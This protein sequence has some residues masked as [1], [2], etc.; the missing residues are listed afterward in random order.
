MKVA[1]LLLVS[2]AANDVVAT[3]SGSDDPVVSE[4]RCYH[5]KAG[6]LGLT[7]SVDVKIDD[8]ASNSAGHIEVVGE[9]I[10]G[11]TCSDK[12]F[13]K[14]GQDITTDLSDCQPSGISIPS[15][16]YCSD[17]DS[18]QVTVRADAVPIPVKATLSRVDCASEQ[19]VASCSGSSDPDWSQPQCYHGK[20]GALGL[21]ENVDVKIDD[22]ANAAGHIEVSGSGIE[23]F[24]CTN[25]PF[26][27]TGQDINTDLT[28]C[29]PD[30]IAITAIKYC[31]D[32]DTIKVTVKDDK[33]PIPVTATMKKVDCASREAVASCSGTADPAV[34]QPV[35]YHGK[36]GA[37]GL[38]ETVDVK[39]DDFANAAGHIEVS[40]DGIESF[41]CSNKPF[42]KSG[43]SINTDLTD[44]QPD[45]IAIT[46]IKYC[47]DQ[48]TIR[49]TV[50]DDTVPIPVS[51]TMKKVT[52]PSVEV[53]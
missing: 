47:S 42:T 11:F 2:A 18:V 4:P 17:Q 50:K 38:T 6:A 20:G 27:K 28:D 45:H 5:G 53:V 36:G 37:L 29:Q 10:E 22:F 44:C 7:E 41:T 35:C 12:P 9:G 52:C 30:H 39:I 32:Q 24:T 40:G 8:F 1:A 25:K 19:A 43:Q 23:D 34:S 21:T 13:S 51:A 16:K 14:D 46:A 26:T 3:C 48:D 49:V 33:V 31:T 15:I